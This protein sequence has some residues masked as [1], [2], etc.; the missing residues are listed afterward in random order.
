MQ[1]YSFKASM[2]GEAEFTRGKQNHEQ[3]KQKRISEPG[4]SWILLAC[5]QAF[6]CFPQVASD[7]VSSHHWQKVS[8]SKFLRLNEVVLLCW[9]ILK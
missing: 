9:Q 7:P 6:S 8:L 2:D 3:E 4:I 5:A 1:G